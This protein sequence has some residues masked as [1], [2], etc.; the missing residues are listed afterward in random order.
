MAGA[1]IEATGTTV[2][3]APD[4]HPVVGVG[5]SFVV[6]PAATMVDD[7]GESALTAPEAFVAVTSTRTV[8]PASAVVSVYVWPVAPEI[9]AQL[10]PL[11]SQRCHW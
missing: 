8:L 1:L 2:P 9:D 4:G 7:V 11:L 5:V 3:A 6:V 10:A